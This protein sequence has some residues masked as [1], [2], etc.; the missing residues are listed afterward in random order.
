MQ[1]RDFL[2]LVRA[3]GEKR[4][5]SIFVHLASG[6][7]RCLSYGRL[8][9]VGVQKLGRKSVYSLS[10]M[11]ADGSVSASRLWADCWAYSIEGNRVTLK[12]RPKVSR[13][14]QDQPNFPDVQDDVSFLI[15][16]PS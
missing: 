8:I 14:P 7:K 5:A 11:L 10:W 13:P 4:T 16:F 2:H 1:V 6:D 12:R 3:L 15:E 9:A